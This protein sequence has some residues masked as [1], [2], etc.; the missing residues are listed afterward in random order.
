MK[1]MHALGM[2]D[3]QQ[4]RM[5][6]KQP[7]FDKTWKDAKEYFE[8]LVDSIETYKMNSGG[9]AGRAKYKSAA[10]IKDK[11]WANQGDEIREY[12]KQLMTQGNAGNE[13]LQQMAETTANV[14][15]LTSTLQQQMK[16]RDKN[17]HVDAANA[18]SDRSNNGI[19]KQSE[20]KHGGKMQC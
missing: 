19:D 4:M 5:W 16:A 1:Q 10:N 8:E 11:E 2:F 12:L 7:E 3:I 17:C 18:N 9:T 6:E 13:K 15:A 14:V 20:C